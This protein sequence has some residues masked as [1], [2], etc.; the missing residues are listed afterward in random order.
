MY[1]VSQVKRILKPLGIFAF[2]AVFTWTLSG[3]QS[4]T[5]GG[6]N[7]RISTNLVVPIG[8]KSGEVFG[9]TVF[10][11]R[12]RGEPIYTVYSINY[13]PLGDATRSG[14]FMLTNLILDSSRSYDVNLPGYHGKTFRQVLPTGEYEIYNIELTSIGMATLRFTAKEPF[15]V[16]FSVGENEKVYLGRFIAHG[17]WRKNM[18]GITVPDGGYFQ[19]ADAMAEDT[20]LAQHAGT[21]FSASQVRDAA[22][23]PTGIAELF[24]RREH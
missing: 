22:L 1:G 3:C 6:A 13:R 15:S 8:A 19:L 5:T 2:V 20:A 21:P 14:F 23:Q 24:L 11:N 17:V 9:S 4:F 18:V 10:S 16:R 12:G 7:S